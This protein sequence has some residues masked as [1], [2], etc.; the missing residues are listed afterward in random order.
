MPFLSKKVK[1]YD[2]GYKPE[3]ISIPKKK[4]E[5]TQRDMQI[6]AMSKI[7]KGGKNSGKGFG[8]GVGP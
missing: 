4:V 8:K 5:K 7:Y 1:L 6:D 3:T 2:S